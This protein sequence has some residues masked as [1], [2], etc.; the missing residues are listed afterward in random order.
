M[1]KKSVLEEALLQINTL[2]EAVKGNAKGILSSVMKKELKNVIKESEDEDEVVEAPED[3]E[4]D[5]LDE[6]DKDIDSEELDTNSEGDDEDMPDFDS[7]EDGDDDMS[8]FG[9]EDGE[10]GGEMPDFDSE[11]D[12]DDEETYDM[13]SAS[14]EEVLKVFK[15][16]SD[17]DGVIIKKDGNKIELSDEDDEYIIKLDDEEFDMNEEDEFEL[18]EEEDEFDMQEEDHDDETVYEIDLD[19]MEDEMDLDEM[20]DHEQEMGES[21]RTKGF[22]QKGGLKGK[23]MFKA[24]RPEMRELNE[25]ISKLKKQNAE[26]K[27]ALVLFKEKLNEVAVFNAN[28][29]HATRLFTEESTTKQEKMT[30]LKRFDNINTISESKNLFQTIK[31]E[32]EGKK[33]MRESMDKKLISTPKTSTSTKT[34]LS[35]SKAYES[36]DLT[37]IR[38]LIK[39]IK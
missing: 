36:P 20:E 3:D 4:M 16:M 26:Y 25:N 5:S 24:G 30:I 1:N 10:E 13:T 6:P 37:R 22:G 17:E 34:I 12:E 18:D 27:K 23:K 28:L 2:E 14:D 33:I 21:A 19:E 7:E 11:D 38:H 15:A 9:S 8:D 32:L 31:S 35:E 29:A 39:V